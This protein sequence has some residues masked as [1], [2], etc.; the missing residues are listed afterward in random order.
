LPNII[1]NV[2][3]E[4]MVAVVE[5]QVGNAWKYSLKTVAAQ[6]SLRRSDPSSRKWV[7]SVIDDNGAGFV[8]QYLDQLFRPFR[9]LHAEI[10]FPGSGG[11]VRDNGVPARAQDSGSG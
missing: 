1:A 5:N 11:K 4:L 9:R 3:A 7:R 10:E 8:Q 6:I 2:D